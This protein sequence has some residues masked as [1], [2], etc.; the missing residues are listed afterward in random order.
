MVPSG[1]W[2]QAR[3]QNLEEAM[4]QGQEA[5]RLNTVQMVL[6]TQWPEREL[7]KEGTI[8]QAQDNTN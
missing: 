5:M 6:N 8:R 1:L 7:N 3:E 2:G 4:L